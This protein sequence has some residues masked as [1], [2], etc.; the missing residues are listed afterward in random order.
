MSM[1]PSPR[2]LV[3]CACLLALLLA[4]RPAGASAQSMRA[5]APRQLG[6]TPVAT[7]LRQLDQGTR[8]QLPKYNQ[9]ATESAIE[10]IVEHRGRLPRARVDSVLTG[11]EQLAR[12]DNE[13]VRLSA[14]MLLAGF[15]R[16][17][18]TRQ[19]LPGMYARLA[20]V[21]E[22]TRDAQLR[23]IIVEAIPRLAEREQALPFLIAL[24]NAPAAQRPFPGADIVAI[25]ALSH[26]GD[27][28][29]SALRRLYERGE[30]RDVRDV[31]TQVLLDNLART[32]GWSA[33]GR[34]APR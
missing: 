4:A 12:S 28:G 21:Y 33:P 17:S 8:G 6:T 24:A 32:R 34:S 5:P 7:L 13:E 11:L 1:R 31:E 3:R 2:Q 27:A 30:L 20:R 29:V 22:T 14:I 16:A 10:E 9:S 25:R 15:G 18:S 19:P 26:T 23:A